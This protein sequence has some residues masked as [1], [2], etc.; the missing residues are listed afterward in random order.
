MQRRTVRLASRLH[1][2]VYRATGG[3]VGHHVAGI[4]TL[5]LTTTGNRTGK[6][7]TVPLLYLEDG[8]RLVVIA[9]Y[10]GRPH[11]P[12][13]YRNLEADPRAIAQVQGRIFDVVT[14]TATGGDRDHLWSRALEAWPGYA[15]YQAKTDRPIPVVW[16]RVEAW[17]TA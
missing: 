14:E 6:R 7:R 5:L 17:R 4:D 1:A 9:S 11:H 12:D 2:S 3:R 8:A 10:G 15:D 13:W 16:L